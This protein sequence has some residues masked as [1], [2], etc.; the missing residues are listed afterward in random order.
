[1]DVP[2][3]EAS[4]RAPYPLSIL[5]GSGGRTAADIAYGRPYGSLPQLVLKKMRW[6]VPDSSLSTPAKSGACA[7]CVLCVEEYQVGR[8]A[9]ASPILSPF[10]SVQ[11][12]EQRPQRRGRGGVLDPTPAALCVWG[13][14]GENTI[15]MT[16]K[17]KPD[18]DPGVTDVPLSRDEIDVYGGYQSV[19]PHPRFDDRGRGGC[20]V[21]RGRPCSTVLDLRTTASQK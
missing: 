18:I 1:M 6:V 5:F 2:G 12:V 16:K 13:G 21:P 4:P 20:L 14:V 19:K 7:V 17:N 9:R 15:F 11:E 10:S 3:L 8:P